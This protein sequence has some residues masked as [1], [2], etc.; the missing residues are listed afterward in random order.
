MRRTIILYACALAAATAIIAGC[1]PSSGPS[2]QVGDCIN[3]TIDSNRAQAPLKV[4]CSHP[5]DPAIDV[6]RAI[7]PSGQSCTVGDASTCEMT[8]RRCAWK[9]STSCQPAAN[10]SPRGCRR[11]RRAGRGLTCRAC[12]PAAGAN[13]PSQ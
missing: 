10:N 12:G 11:K 13:L 2:F 8:A 6:V 9:T 7:A 3:W 4:N 5:P 1:G